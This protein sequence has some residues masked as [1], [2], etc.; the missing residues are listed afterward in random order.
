MTAAVATAAAAIATVEQAEAMNVALGDGKEE[1]EDLGPTI[2]E[3]L[4]ADNGFNNQ[5]RLAMLWTMHDRWASMCRFVLNCHR[6][7]VRLVCRVPR[8]KLHVI[9]SR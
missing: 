6:H 2:A 4:D 3:M 7:E 1:V 8:G 5:S 9:H